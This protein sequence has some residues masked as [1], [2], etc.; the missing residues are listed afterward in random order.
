MRVARR[1]GFLCAQ[2]TFCFK[3]RGIILVESTQ[4]RW[5]LRWSGGGGWSGRAVAQRRP[6]V[7]KLGLKGLSDYYS[8][9]LAVEAAGR[10]ASGLK[11]RATLTEHLLKK[12]EL[13]NS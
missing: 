11:K 10:G 8:N 9:K 2:R 3:P 13:D 12:R 4:I 5:F 7:S 1:F 6:R